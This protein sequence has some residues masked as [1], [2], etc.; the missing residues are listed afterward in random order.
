MGK[1]DETVQLKARKNDAIRFD[2]AKQNGVIN[3]YETMELNKLNKY[4]FSK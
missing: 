1:N 4:H 2:R 3:A